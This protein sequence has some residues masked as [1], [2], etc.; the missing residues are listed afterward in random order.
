[1]WIDLPDTV[2]LL[3]EKRAATAFELPVCHDGLCKGRG[4]GHKAQRDHELLGSTRVASSDSM[5]H[6]PM[7][8]TRTRQ[9]GDGRVNVD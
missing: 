6:Q 1:M 4:Q 5:T 8:P 3:E 7:S 2:V 9:T